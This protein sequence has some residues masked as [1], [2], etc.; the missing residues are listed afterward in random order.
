MLSN[1]SLRL[2]LWRIMALERGG[3]EGVDLRTREEL[4]VRDTGMDKEETGLESA[5]CL[6]VDVDDTDD[7][8]EE[9]EEDMDLREASSFRLY[10]WMA[11][12]GE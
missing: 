4:W 5:G 8:E 7:E 10:K 6:L 3:S 1:P 9:E 2:A 12:R 11:S